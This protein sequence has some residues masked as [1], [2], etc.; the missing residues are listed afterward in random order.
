MLY[1]REKLR[2]WNGR[3]GGGYSCAYLQGKVESVEWEGRG[4]AKKKYVVQTVFLLL[5]VIICRRNYN[6]GLLLNINPL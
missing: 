3:G 6:R 1:C 2:V 4:C 5:S